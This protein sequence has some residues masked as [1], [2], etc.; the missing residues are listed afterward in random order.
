MHITAFGGK[1]IATK[2]LLYKTILHSPRKARSDTH[3]KHVLPGGLYSG[4]MISVERAK[5]V[6]A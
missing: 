4:N 2:N 6:I 3:E 1:D 5:Q